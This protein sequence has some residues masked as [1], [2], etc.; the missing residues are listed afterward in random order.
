MG[1]PILDGR[2]SRVVRSRN[3]AS[4]LPRIRLAHL[5]R[6]HVDVI[7]RNPAAATVYFQDWRHLA[8]SRFEDVR[9]RRD[10]Y[11]ALWRQ[12]IAEGVA[13]GELRPI[14][15][16]LAAIACLSMCN[17]LYQ[18]YDPSGPLSPGDV[19]RA[20]A[21]ILIGGLGRSGPPTTDSEKEYA[22]AGL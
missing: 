2:A 10:A 11:E 9:A 21:D 13:S 16:R 14:E 4:T 17:W 18:W 6:A 19:A 15:P 20:F 8:D 22:H 5:I 3:V 12:L 1:Q 7:G